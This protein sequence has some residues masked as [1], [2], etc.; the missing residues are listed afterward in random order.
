ML[1]PHPGEPQALRLVLRCLEF[2][3]SLRIDAVLSGGSK[4]SKRG[5][6]TEEDAADLPKSWDKVP[7]SFC[8]ATRRALLLLEHEKI[9][10]TLAAQVYWLHVSY[11]QVAAAALRSGAQLTALLYLEHWCEEQLGAYTV[12]GVDTSTQVLIARKYSRTLRETSARGFMPVF[13]RYS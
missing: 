7:A 12:D 3:R 5:G 1:G 10:M 4:K 13:Q 8:T 2:L 9:F 6:R 11:L